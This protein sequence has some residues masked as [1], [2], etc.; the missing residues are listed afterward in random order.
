MAASTTE[1]SDVV[2][3][4]AG[5]YGLAAAAHLRAAGVETRVFGRTMEFWRERMP[6]KM[7]LRS[8]REASHIS[9]PQ[10]AL[11]LDRHSEALN[12]PLPDP[13][14]ISDF[15]EYGDWFQRQAVPDV[16]PRRIAGITA[17]KQGF[18]LSLEDGEAV[19]AR[20]VVVA[21]G[22]ERFAWTP[23]A[24]AHLSP[25]LVSHSSEHRDFERFAG[26]RVLVVG[27]GQSALESAALLSEASAEVDVVIRAA[28]VRWLAPG[29]MKK[30]SELLHRILYP[31]SDVGP[32][33]LNWLVFFP[34]LWRM[35]P[36]RRRN[37]VAY[38]CIRPAAAVWLRDRLRSAKVRTSRSIAGLT[39]EGGTLR[40]GLDDGSE[41]HVDHVLA[42][43]GFRVDVSR[44]DFLDHDLVRS[45]EL[46]DGYP[47]LGRGFES[48]VPGLHF[49]GAPAAASFGPIMRFVAGTRY[50]APSLV[51][52]V[53]PRRRRTPF[54]ERARHVAAE[55]R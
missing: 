52:V 2:V 15:I 43:T 7:L 48:S 1:P 14:P 3:V 36:E 53:A 5:P 29:E 47:V 18:R 4:G 28:Q 33:G 34:W 25:G 12:A 45:L 35:L 16:D 21:A 49:L 38:R 41:R 20:R 30:R 22:L 26:R 42:A 55:T 6:G 17:A 23:P 8:I 51:R 10:R 37:W 40:V 19:T 39:E 11:T 13:I 32:P 9:D 44:Y 24:L 27:G 50:A 54:P 46:V 31:P